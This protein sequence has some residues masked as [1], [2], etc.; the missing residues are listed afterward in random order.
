MSDGRRPGRVR[1]ALRVEPLESRALMAAP[2][3]TASGV[4]LSAALNKSFSKT[5]ASF[6]TSL[7]GEK[8][9][10]F[11]ATVD[12]GDGTTGIGT[13]KAAKGK[14]KFTVT[15]KHAYKDG[16]SQEEAT[17][18]ITGP[19]GSSAQAR[20]VV[21]IGGAR[22]ANA[23]AVPIVASEGVDASDLIIGSFDVKTKDAVSA[24]NFE[25]V[26]APNLV[27]SS[28]I[29]VLGTARVV[30]DRSVPRRFNIVLDEFRSDEPTDNPN[31]NDKERV[32]PNFFAS[33]VSYETKFFRGKFLIRAPID[34]RARPIAADGAPLTFTAPAGGAWT[35]TV[36][37][38][39]NPNLYDNQDSGDYEAV[40]DWGDGSAPQDATG[41]FKRATSDPG[42]VTNVVEGGHR[43]AAARDY[44]VT[45]T[46]TDLDTGQKLVLKATAHVVAPV[47][48][49]A[50]PLPSGV[51]G[52]PIADPDQ[53]DPIAG[54]MGDARVAFFDTAGRDD[55][56]D[57]FHYRI[58]WGDGSTGGARVVK[59][60][61][62]FVMYANHTYGAA[63][64]Y[65]VKIQ[66]LDLNDNVLGEVSEDE[67]VAEAP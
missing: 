6:V 16:L 30:A 44:T 60:A 20:T 56:P 39:K 35:G 48:M 51:A 29:S 67:I 27:A 25:V 36:A 62:S 18:K 53:N 42:G 11:R 9:R 63:G 34:V 66:V 19:E 55:T 12:W 2:V 17:I 24:V 49:Q 46:I 43:Y 10:D 15:G 57:S 1:R 26:S 21:R 13:I 32:A 4:N 64:S 8:A 5:V 65:R 41:T 22:F 28:S 3:L 7:T 52:R 33:V 61:G 23:T 50:V 14:G 59:R 37:R 38:F 54:T 31:P 58:A 47:H 40:I 45:T